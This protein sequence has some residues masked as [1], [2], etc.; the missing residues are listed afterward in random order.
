MNDMQDRVQ[1]VQQRKGSAPR[2]T[3]GWSRNNTRSSGSGSSSEE[4]DRKLLESA[5]WAHRDTTATAKSALQVG[6]QVVRTCTAPYPA[7]PGTLALTRCLPL[8]TLHTGGDRDNRR[9]GIYHC[10]PLHPGPAAGPGCARP[11]AGR[12]T[13]ALLPVNPVRHAP[14]DQPTNQSTDCAHALQI[15]E[16]VQHA[17]RVV[18]FMQRFCSCM[19]PDPDAEL[20]SLRA[21]TVRQ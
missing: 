17:G 7:P 20:D 10:I 6:G 8:T 4:R 13:P 18:R 14:T 5:K 21:D 16:D 1:H 11:R 3:V 9:G 19:R 2:A 15:D 12:C